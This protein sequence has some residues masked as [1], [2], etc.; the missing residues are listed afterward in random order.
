[1]KKRDYKKGEKEALRKYKKGQ[2]RLDA[3]KKRLG[4]AKAARKKVE[5]KYSIGKVNS[6]STK[7]FE[8]YIKTQTRAPKIMLKK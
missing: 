1:M 5:L 4:K 3:S 8:R 2:K 6:T 7:A